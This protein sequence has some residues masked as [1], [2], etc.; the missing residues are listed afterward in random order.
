VSEDARFVLVSRRLLDDDRFWSGH[1]AVIA[2]AVIRHAGVEGRTEVSV[3]AIARET[4]VHEATVR[5]VLRVMAEADFVRV[6]DGMTIVAARERAR[7]IDRGCVTAE[8]ASRVSDAPGACVSDA[9]DAPGNG[10]ILRD[11]RD[12]LP[13]SV[14]HHEPASVTHHEP[15]SAD[16]KTRLKA[17]GFPVDSSGCTS[18]SHAIAH[19]PAP[20][21]GIPCPD[22]YIHTLVSSVEI[23][24][25]GRE[26]QRLTDPIP[27]STGPTPLRAVRATG[28]TGGA[29]VSPAPV[30]ASLEPPDDD[31]DPWG[32]MGQRYGD[33]W[34]GPGA[35]LRLVP[36]D[37]IEAYRTEWER[38]TGR[39]C[40]TLSEMHH[41]KRLTLE[42]Q[43]LDAIED[44]DLRYHARKA[45]G[46]WFDDPY[47]AQR[48]WPLALLVS[49]IG[50]IMATG[51][52]MEP[53]EPDPRLAGQSV[54]YDDDLPF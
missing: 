5:R 12:L 43:I 54:A 32:S 39:P 4:Q 33:A 46:L 3:R 35:E 53:G 30:S 9:P 2:Y 37:V 47:P 25:R 13:A 49:Q 15:A 44:G 40:G 8:A 7:K 42:R 48:R 26:A 38:R 34:M 24:D 11:N 6:G 10:A 23:G 21:R 27:S 50:R 1:H 29:E 31:P 14:T 51:R 28:D 19:V 20:A 45:V 16:W 52:R 41:G 22:N 36:H 17:H 18:D